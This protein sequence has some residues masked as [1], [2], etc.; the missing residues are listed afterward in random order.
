MSK[1]LATRSLFFLLLTLGL[2]CKDGK[3]KAFDPWTYDGEYPQ[4]MNGDKIKTYIPEIQGGEIDARF[5]GHT[6]DHAPF[7][8]T[9][10]HI[11]NPPNS[12]SDQQE[13]SISIQS[14]LTR[15]HIEP[16]IFES[17]YFRVPLKIGRL[18]L[19]EYASGMQ[20]EYNVTDFTS[21]NCDAGKDHY[22]LNAGKQSW[23][24]ITSYDST[25]REIQATFEVSYQMEDRNSDFGPIYPEHVN[26]QGR[27]KTVAS[28]RK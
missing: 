17:F 7:L 4:S 12:V 1:S 11:W 13:I 20:Y 23:V 14:L 18:S 19:N 28:K 8:E 16:C 15:A 27:I 2:A 25:T 6:W 10:A 21:M 9:T 5:N 22:K 3:E 26:I 24:E